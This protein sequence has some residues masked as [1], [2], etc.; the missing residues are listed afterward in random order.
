M[1]IHLWT[2]ENPT[3]ILGPIRDIVPLRAKQRRPWNE[4]RSPPCLSH[5]VDTFINC[6]AVDFVFSL[7]MLLVI[8]GF[9]GARWTENFD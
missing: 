5:N 7:G 4:C 9:Y 6:Q 1:L 3:G 8:Y 2:S